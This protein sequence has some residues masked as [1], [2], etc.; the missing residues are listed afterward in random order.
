[1]DLA[2]R[3]RR[4]SHRQ[5]VVVKASN[6]QYE[7]LDKVISIC[8]SEVSGCWMHCTVGPLVVEEAVC[9][10][11]NVSCFL[12]EGEARHEPRAL[13]LCFLNQSSR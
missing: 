13:L 12:S 10:S 4:R 8:C 9:T 1:M 3:R 6:L 5:A 2:E 7:D 11:V